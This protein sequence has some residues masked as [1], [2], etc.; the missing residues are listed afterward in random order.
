MLKFPQGKKP[1]LEAA[2]PGRV[3]QLSSK[4]ARSDPRQQFK[5]ELQ[6]DRYLE[7]SQRS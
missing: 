2:S 7:G 5:G 6:S 4:K 1:R 3:I